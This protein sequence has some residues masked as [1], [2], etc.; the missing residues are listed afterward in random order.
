MLYDDEIVERVPSEPHDCT[1][2]VVVTP[3]RTVWL[4]PRE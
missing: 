2:D 3:M 4:T 1:V